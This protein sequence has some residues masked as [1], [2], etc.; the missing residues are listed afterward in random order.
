M[1]LEIEPAG[2]GWRGAVVE[3][4]GR[5]RPFEA[6]GREVGEGRVEGDGE[7]LY[8]RLTPRPM[9]VEVVLAPLGADGRLRADGVRALAFLRPGVDIPDGPERALPPPTRAGQKVEARGFVSSFAWWSPLEAA[10]GWEGIEP[11]FRA[12]I[13]LFPLVLSDL[14]GKICDSPE[15]TPGLSEALRGQGVGC[16]EVSAAF[17]RMRAGAGFDR[18]K[19][20]VADERATLLQVLDCADDVTRTQRD[21]AAAA[22]ETARRAVSMETVATVLSQYR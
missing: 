22:A 1:R 16:K 3:A 12:T 5:R 8:L 11:R 10:W 18:F 6:S 13:R 2:E 7:T 14:A 21:C 9:G 19:R 4:D 15:R 20:A 17:A